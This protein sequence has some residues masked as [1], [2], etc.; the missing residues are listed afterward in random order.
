MKVQFK[1]PEFHDTRAVKWDFHVT[2]QSMG[3]GIILGRNLMV[4]LGL[5]IDFKDL[6]LKWDDMAVPM[7][8]IDVTPGQADA[9]HVQ[10]GMSDE[11][12]RL[13]CI[14]DAKYQPAFRP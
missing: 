11:A 8:S 10:D 9:F 2:S 1:L 3:Y 4:E 14:L 12:N 5:E 6:V 7:K 13:Q